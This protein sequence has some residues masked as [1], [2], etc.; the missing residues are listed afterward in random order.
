MGRAFRF[1]RWSLTTSSRSDRRRAP[2]PEAQYRRARLVADTYGLE[3][4]GR[5]LLLEA[6]DDAME[7]GGEFMRRRIAAGD[8]NFAAIWEEGG[9]QARFDRRRA[10]WAASRPTFAA[11]LHPETPSGD[12]STANQ[13]RAG[14]SGS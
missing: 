4:T 11:A 5:R 3:P 6:L 12:Q 7:R 2:G 13:P 1:S 8:A 14:S 10:W 9:G